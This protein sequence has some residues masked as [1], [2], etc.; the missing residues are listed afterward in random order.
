MSQ[1]QDNLREILRQK[2]ARLMP[3]NLRKD[4]QL[5]GVTGTVVELVGETK[6]IVPSTSRQIVTPSQGH[7][8][9]TEITVEAVDNTIDPN[10]IA[11]NIKAGVTILGITGTYMGTDISL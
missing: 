1:L 11:D 2:N 7:N 5:L 4:I 9:I 10:L 8:A 3:D 6:T